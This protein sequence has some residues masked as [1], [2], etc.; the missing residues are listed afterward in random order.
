MPPTNQ[1]KRQAAKEVV[2]V[3]LEISTLL[4]TGLN[5]SQLSICV[6][7]IEHGTNPEALAAVV[8]EMRKEAEKIEAEKS[9][10]EFTS[11]EEE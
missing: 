11:A 1:E 10:D 4:N 9:K 3:L 6:S 7:M 5:R 2:D 8:K